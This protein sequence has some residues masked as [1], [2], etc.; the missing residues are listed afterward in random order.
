MNMNGTRYAVF[1][2]VCVLKPSG[3]LRLSHRVKY[4]LN[5]NVW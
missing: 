5:K 2:L 1:I 3:L 4:G